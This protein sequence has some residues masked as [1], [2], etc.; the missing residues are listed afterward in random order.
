MAGPVVTI[1]RQR[2]SGGDELA[3][4]VAQQLGVPLLDHEI[5]A[6]AAHAAG[7]SEQALQASQRHSGLLSRMLENL[8]RFGASGGEGVAMEGL[9]SSA[10]F[11]TS[12]DFRRLLEKVLREVA[13]SGPAVIVGHAGQVILR[14]TPGTLHVFVHAPVEYRAARIAHAEQLSPVAARAEVEQSDRERVRFYR[15]AYHADWYDLR[16][17]DLVVDTSILT[18]HGAAAMIAEMAKQA[19]VTTQ[20][21]PLPEAAAAASAIAAEG[22]DDEST[23][24]RV[25]GA[26]LRVR[27]MTPADAGGLLALCRSLPPLDLLFL[28]NDV[29]DERVIDAWA[30][31]VADGRIVTMLAESPD[32]EIAGMASLRPSDVPWTQHVGEVRVITS[33]T[34][35]ARGLGR[36]LMKE[37]MHAARAAGIEKLTAEMTVEQSGARKLFE[38]LGFKEEGRFRNYARDQEGNLHDLVVMTHT[39]G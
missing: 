18:V 14:D 5:I 21:P 27:P 6:R 31:D 29:T 19:C 36:A 34:L 39:A 10:L 4:L 22:G 2:G 13:E 33:P 30:R 17:Y 12:A 32:G 28:R 38:R 16:L 23:E 37:I 26:E 24:L 8:G 15:S 20:E 1:A 9:S 3:A 25:D 35:R 11:A 7:V